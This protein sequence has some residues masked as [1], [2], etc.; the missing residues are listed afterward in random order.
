MHTRPGAVEL[1]GAPAIVERVHPLAMVYG[2]GGVFGMVYCLGVAHGL[3]AAG[4]P[5]ATAPALGTSAGAWAASAV[6]LGVDAAD[7]MALDFPHVPNPR[8]GALAAI[9]RMY[10]GD[11]THH[12]VSVSAVRVPSGR[13]HILD[14]GRYPLADLAAASSS[15]PVLFPPHVIDGH[16]YVDGG[17]WSATSIDAATAAEHVVVVAPVAGPV[18]RPIGMGAGMLLGR[19]LGSWRR[20]HP[21]HH[22]TFIR[23]NHAIARM[24]GRNP[25]GLFDS[26]RARPVYPLAFEQ[27]TRMAAQLLTG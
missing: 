2:G 19:E 4:V 13:R 10:F 11:A 12:L 17:M 7:L 1:D 9:A 26:A 25:L 5:V 22:I 21:A 8:R 27:G 15:V 24:A 14:G 3:A 23:P 18:M 20:R 16:S 6:A